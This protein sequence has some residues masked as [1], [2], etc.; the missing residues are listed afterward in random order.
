MLL[1]V[2]DD[3]ANVMQGSENC[4]SGP[5]DDVG[6]PRADSGPG[7]KPIRWSKA[8]MI[9]LAS[10]SPSV[11]DHLMQLLHFIYLRNQQEHAPPAVHGGLDSVEIQ[12]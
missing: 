5:D 2:H 11:L 10:R 9:V 1:S 6:L 12:L 7:S 8:G 3:E 4:R